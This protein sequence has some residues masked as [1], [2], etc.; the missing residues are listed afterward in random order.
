MSV[1]GKKAKILGRICMDQTIIDVTDIEGVKIGDEV[2]VFSNG[3][4]NAPTAN[5]LA[6][7]A[8]TINYEI[9]CAVSKRVPR[10]YIKNGKIVD[11]MYKL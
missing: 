11:V 9:I 6:E 3:A 1:K 10:E 2:T 7:M 5:D 4:D 8:G